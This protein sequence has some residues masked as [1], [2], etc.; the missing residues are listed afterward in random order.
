[1][2]KKLTQFRWLA[3]TLMLVAAMV[4]PSTAWAEVTTSQPA[5][6]DG[7]AKSPYEITTAAELA[8]FRDLVNTEKNRTACARL[9]ADIDMSSVCHAA[10][11]SQGVTELSWVPISDESQVGTNY[12]YGTFDGNNKTISN[13]YINTSAKYSGLFGYIYNMK[14]SDRG[15]IKNIKFENVSVAS[16][17]D[18]LGVLAGYA[19]NA[20][21]SGIM[22]NSGTV[23]GTG[24][25]GG[26]VGYTSGST[27][28]SCINKINIVGSSSNTGGIVGYAI[29]SSITNCA[30]YGDVQSYR[31]VGGIA[32][33]A[34]GTTIEN[35]FSSG[36]VTCSLTISS[37]ANTG[38]VV[39]HIYQNVTISGNVIYNSE[40]NLYYGTTRQDTK[41]FGGISS[42]S[43]VTE[44]DATGLTSVQLQ[45]GWGTWLLNGSK[46]VG[47][48]GQNINNDNYP[49]L[50]GSVI[51]PKDAAMKCTYTDFSGT[52]TNTSSEAS[53]VT[54]THVNYTHY[55]YIAPT[56]VEGRKEYYECNDCHRTF[57]DAAM[58][59]ALENIVIERVNNHHDFGNDHVCKNCSFVMP[60]AKLGDAYI[61]VEK[62]D[63]LDSQYGYKLFKYVADGTGTLRVKSY[64][65]ADTEGA[66]WTSVGS[67][68]TYST[69]NDNASSSETDFSFAYNVTQGE[70]YIIGIRQKSHEAIDGNYILR[71]RGS[72]TETA[73][74]VGI[75]PF[76]WNGEGT[77]VS[78]YELTSACHLLWFAKLVNNG[79]TT[80]CARMETDIDLGEVC[81]AADES[82]GVSELSWEPISQSSNPWYGSFDGNNYTISNLYIN[83]SSQYSG[84]FGYVGSSSGRC[85]IK[86]IKFKNVNINSTDHYVGVLAGKAHKTDIIGIMVNSGIISGYDMVGGIVGNT[87]DADLSYCSNRISV[88]GS[89]EVGGLIGLS[90]SASST[91]SITNCAN[92]GDVKGN[93]YSGGI[94]GRTY[95]LT[96]NNVLTS[97]NV[98]NVSPTTSCSGLVVG[99][100]NENMTIQ[101]YA[102]YNSD[103]KLIFNT[104]EQPANALGDKEEGVTIT[105]ESNIM[106]LSSTRLASGEACYLLNGSSPYGEWGQQ[107]DTNDYPVLGSAYKV[108]RAARDGENGTNYWATFSNLDSNAELTAPTGNVTVYNATVSGSTLTLTKRIDDRVAAG[109]GVLL[110]AGCE[111]LNA[112]NISETVSAAAAGENDLV[113]TPA[114]T[115]TVTADDGY[116]LYRLT[117][118]DGESKE[119]LGFYLGVVG[120]S[121]DGSQLKATPGKAYLNVLTSEATE[122]ST[123]KLARGFAFPGDGETTG[124]ECITVTDESL[125]RNGNADIFDLQGRKVSKPTKGVYINN[126]KKVVINL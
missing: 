108:L 44:N 125:Y 102:F 28:S 85:S 11:E 42:S 72:W 113:A 5:N 20:D 74:L 90:A 89:K 3:A 88:E 59:I 110:K 116:T 60:E 45:N 97:G 37:T 30:N 95:N 111:Y 43:T 58:T 33:S 115:Q 69:Y 62:V 82:N 36:D 48:W 94:A 6:G 120:E 78:P 24:Y 81:H 91:P 14:A 96:L 118:N 63:D 119:G 65:D 114:T 19:R 104:S 80:A 13:L 29:S 68:V 77:Q 106:G 41:A 7:S 52:F 117:Y 70:T 50:D 16:T 46:S 18:Y 71:L 39:G 66:I 53:S 10:N 121:K 61:I 76:V 92:F 25:C 12:W 99:K 112:M 23:N 51:Y 15:T 47:V 109:E 4:M 57:T 8:W 124:I 55:E 64:G 122:P 1:M 84:L 40:A 75:E 107:I 105:E 103:A 54:L 34:E 73:D 22:V 56:C 17:V 31:M 87:S 26:I 67:D 123:A 2:K 9:E 27:L 126:G 83:T 101:G 100:V 21:I 86:N 38:L 35:V 93:Y 79:N 49:V 32:G 98:T